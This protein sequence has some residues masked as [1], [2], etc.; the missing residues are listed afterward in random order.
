MNGLL[1]AL[2]LVIYT[3]S[4]GFAKDVAQRT[5][6]HDDE[7]VLFSC[8]VQGGTKTVSLCGSRDLTDKAG[9][10]QYRFGRAGNLE[11]EFPPQRRETWRMFRYSHYF[12]YQVDRMAVRFDNNGFTYT[13]FDSY[14]G[15]TEPKVRQQGVQ[16]TLPEK[17]RKDIII[18]C[19]ATAVGNLRRLI[20]LV[21]CDTDDASNM[22]ECR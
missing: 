18:L 14:E 9:Y 10:L 16:I 2:A 13:L 19:H 15:D 3:Q 8:P 20:A 21:P 4:S 11:L 22:G 1:L 7:Q 5:L 6:C 12:R 17:G